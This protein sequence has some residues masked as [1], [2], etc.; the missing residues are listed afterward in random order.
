M[1]LLL[2]AY[3]GCPKSPDVVLQ[4]NI[5]ENLVTTEMAWVPK[6]ASHT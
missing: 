1:F 5:L 4:C 3:T 6:D 2:A